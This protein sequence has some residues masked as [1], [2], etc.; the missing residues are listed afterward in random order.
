MWRSP[1]IGINRFEA[2]AQENVLYVK[3][4]V[5][6]RSSSDVNSNQQQSKANTAVQHGLNN[7]ETYIGLNAVA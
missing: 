2:S 4:M 5:G 7:R 3:M 1:F 6:P